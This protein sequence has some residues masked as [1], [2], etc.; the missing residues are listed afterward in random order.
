MTVS[1]G[2]PRII[3]M[4]PARLGSQRLKQKNLL[5]IDGVPLYTRALRKVKDLPCFAEVWANSEA[6]Q[7]GD[8][9]RAEGVPFHKRPESLGSHTATSEDFV[10]EF[11]MAHPCDYLVQVHSIAPLLT[12]D[13]ITRFTEA[14]VSGGH[15][16]LLS[17]VNEQIQCMMADEPLNFSRTLM[18]MTQEL[19]PIQRISWSLT[20]WRRDSYIATY[21]ARECA[22]FH[23]RMGFFNLRRPSG[24]VI[25]YEE[26]YEMVCAMAA[27]GIGD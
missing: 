3:A 4:I 25:K 22:T 27:A 26:D 21:E 2:A 12:R 8:L 13:E 5:E 17:G 14:L 16:T 24:L 1:S 6:D 18:D 7:I 19:V 20:G 11:L 15:E 10:Y 9:A 23:G